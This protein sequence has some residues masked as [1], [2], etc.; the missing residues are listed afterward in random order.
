M[1]RVSNACTP[2]RQP[3]KAANTSSTLP[4]MATCQQIK[5]EEGK[6]ERNGEKGGKKREGRKGREGKGG[7]EREGREQGKKGRRGERERKERR[8]GR[9]EGE[10]KERREGREGRREEK[11]GKREQGERK[12]RREEGE[13]ERKERDESLF[14]SVCW[15]LSFLRQ[16]RRSFYFWLVG[17]TPFCAVACSF[18]TKKKSSVFSPCVFAFILLPSNL[19]FNNVAPP[20]LPFLSSLWPP[21]VLDYSFPALF[22]SLRVLLRC[23]HIPLLLLLV[24]YLVL[25]LAFGVVGGFFNV[26]FL[27]AN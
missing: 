15:Q 21:R 8:E 13:R 18:A 10:R 26:S 27:A 2:C 16:H 25:L 6:V 7:K 19:N 22:S 17:Y 12:E 4:I 5:R 14:V 1:I 23:C 20:L 3:Q 9:E 11:G 24:D